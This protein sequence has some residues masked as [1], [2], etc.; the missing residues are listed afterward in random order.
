MLSLLYIPQ[1]QHIRGYLQ[2]IAFG[3]KEKAILHKFGILVHRIM[4]GPGRNQYFWQW[5]NIRILQLTSRVFISYY[6][7]TGFIERVRCH[8]LL[9]LKYI[10]LTH[11]TLEL[12]GD[13]LPGLQM[14]FTILNILKSLLIC[15]EDMLYLRTGEYLFQM[16]TRKYGI[17]KTIL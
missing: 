8:N 13:L 6:Q 11:R 1:W 3:R 2:S 10:I 14:Q 9:N 7:A 4:E 15:K 5:A 16:H 12:L 17:N